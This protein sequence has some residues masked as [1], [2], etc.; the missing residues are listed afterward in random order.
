MELIAGSFLAVA[1]SL[2]GHLVLVVC[3]HLQR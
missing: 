1:L 2:V 3:D